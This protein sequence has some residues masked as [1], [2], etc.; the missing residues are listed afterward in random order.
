M[1]NRLLPLFF[2]LSIPVPLISMVGEIDIESTSPL[3]FTVTIGDIP[4]ND[5]LNSIDSGYV[6]QIII[7]YRLY[8]QKETFLAKDTL[9]GSSKR[10]SLIEI[11]IISQLYRLNKDNIV[12]YYSREE[13][14]ME[15]FLTDI[16]YIPEIKI[17]E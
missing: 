2:F 6:S 5:I 17:T 1:G 14:L 10:S 4:Q 13:R 9:I 8:K 3:S 12:S 16:F 7:E 15:E 11:D